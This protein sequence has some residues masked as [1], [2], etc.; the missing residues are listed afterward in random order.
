MLAKL[1]HTC[2]KLKEQ[3]NPT[4]NIQYYTGEPFIINVPQVTI[5]TTGIGKLHDGVYTV[6]E[7]IDQQTEEIVKVFT[8]KVYVDPEWSTNIARSAQV[9]VMPVVREYVRPITYT[10]NNFSLYDEDTRTNKIFNHIFVV[11]YGA[12]NSNELNLNDLHTTDGNLYYVHYNYTGLKY[13]ED[14]DLKYDGVLNTY[15]NDYLYQGQFLAV[16]YFLA[17][18]TVLV[19]RVTVNWIWTYSDGHTETTY[20]SGALAN[21]TNFRMGIEIK[22]PKYTPKGTSTELY[23]EYVELFVNNISIWG[24]KLPI[25]KCRPQDSV[26]LWFI[27]NNGAL[28]FIHCDLVCQRTVNADRTQMTK[29]ATIQNRT[30]FGK[31]NYSTDVYE[32]YSLNT[33]IMSD[34][35]SKK[36]KNIFTS[37]YVWLQ[38][39]SGMMHSVVLTEKSLTIKKRQTHKIFNYTIQCEDSQT[40]NL[41]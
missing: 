13:S 35:L 3:I 29:Y 16:D 8:G 33:Q 5:G 10:V 21:N 38:D 27:S 7:L 34:E 31:F 2:I 6:Y 18:N 20:G 37:N 39:T 11:A 25:L 36:M 24:K 12:E 17:P 30:L 9:D 40:V 1:V 14:T 28:D 4:M 22:G 19:S 41:I 26:T 15:Y 23:P 32:S